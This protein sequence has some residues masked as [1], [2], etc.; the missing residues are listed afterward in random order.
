[1]FQTGPSV[2]YLNYPKPVEIVCCHECLFRVANIQN[3]A[4]LQLKVQQVF[5]SQKKGDMVL[6][7]LST[8]T[9]GKYFLQVQSNGISHN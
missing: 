4:G 5:I 9:W 8:S 7:H 2:L 1:M 3:N 6:Q